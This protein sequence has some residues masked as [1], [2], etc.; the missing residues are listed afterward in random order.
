MCF[1]ASRL[2][3]VEVSTFRSPSLFIALLLA[4]ISY[5]VLASLLFPLAYYLC[6]HYFLLLLIIS[7][8]VLAV[9]AL[10]PLPLAVLASLLFP[11]AYYLRLLIIMCTCRHGG[12]AKRLNEF[13][14]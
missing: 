3:N 5:Y 13:C 9:Q 8:A 4:M 1:F 12:F 2:P 6:K 11:L 7:I 10:F 14:L